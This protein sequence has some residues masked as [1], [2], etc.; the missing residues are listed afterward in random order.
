MPRDAR[1]WLGAVA[2][3]LVI[4]LVSLIIE[5]DGQ[6]LP[7]LPLEQKGASTPAEKPPVVA[8]PLST[9]EPF[10]GLGTW[11]D[12]YDDRQWEHPEGAVREMAVNGVQTL[13][14]Q[15]AN[16][17]TKVDLFKPEKLGRF[18]ES[19]HAEGIA[20]VAWYLPDF[21]NLERDLRRSR[22][23]IDFRTVNGERFDRF[24]LD[25]EATVV[26]DVEDRNRRVIRLTKDIRK[27]AGDMA[28]GG[29]TP[30][31]IGSLYW[32]NFPFRKVA[33][34]Y[35]VIMP[36]G[37]FTY[38]TSGAVGVNDHVW[39]GIAALQQQRVKRDRIHYI[40]GLSMDASAAEVRAYRD[41]AMELGTMGGSIY[42]FPDTTPEHWKAL[43]PLR[44]LAS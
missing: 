42:D 25:I 15:T 2:F 31:P 14:L 21:Q 13:Y 44:D 41:A 24:A 3:A 9:V 28:L 6:A 40:G 27:V 17:R 18:I 32:P 12:I 10:R 26:D 22:A 38:R 33:A 30:D 43:K 19:A 7:P 20:V 1:P 11:V 39:A 8:T 16:Y 37:Y 4:A 34:N 29:I 35:D 23:A 36:M 5:P